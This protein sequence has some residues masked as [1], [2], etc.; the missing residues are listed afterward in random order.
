M[1]KISTIYKVIE[2]I[3]P[4]KILILKNRK[5]SK[6]IENKGGSDMWHKTLLY[7]LLLI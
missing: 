4:N 3:M 7:I 1:D 5:N 2:I 6:N